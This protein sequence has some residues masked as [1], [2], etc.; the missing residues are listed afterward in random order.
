MVEA[1]LNRAAATVLFF[2]ALAAFG[3]CNSTTANGYSCYSDADCVQGYLCD[4]PS[5]VCFA[6]TA[7]DYDSCRAP[8]DCASSYTCG[9]AG[10][11]MPG[12]CYF[13][14]CIAGYECSSSTGAWQC[15]P[16]ASGAAGVGNE[17]TNEAGTG[18]V[19]DAAGQSG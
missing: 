11:C 10:L 18:G 15:L 4:Y 16:S 3:G 14:G 13:N 9:K 19:R 7:G 17:D 1:A 2:T 5:G 12:D 6:A 8:A